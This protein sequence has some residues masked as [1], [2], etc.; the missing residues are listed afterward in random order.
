MDLEG[1]GRRLREERERLGLNQDQFAALA[2]TGRM[3]VYRYEL[4]AH[5]PTLAFLGLVSPAGVD[6][7]Y[8]LKGKRAVVPLGVDD[9]A[10]LGRAMTVIDD[11]LD[12]HNFQPS[13]ELRG[14]LV[15]QVLRDALG[16]ARE[17]K[18]VAPSLEKLI[19]ELAR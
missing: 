13:E 10:L 15:L 12:K 5:L 17:R 16:G 14:R 6:V 11:L 1:V 19:S 3:T 18:A 8:V 9:A 2:D 4:G 7:D